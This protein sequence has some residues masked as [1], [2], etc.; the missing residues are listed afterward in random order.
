MKIYV[1]RH[2]QDEDNAAGI[3]N[4]HR[5]KRL[6]RL[7]RKQAIA[8]RFK[9]KELV[10]SPDKVEVSPLGRAIETAIIAGFDR[11]YVEPG[12]IERDFGS[13]T[14]KPIFSAS[15]TKKETF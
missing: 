8:L 13:M 7:G 11:H 1:A 15:P 5:N 9:V 12:L 4:G 14:G 6:T 3:L 10:I 2:G